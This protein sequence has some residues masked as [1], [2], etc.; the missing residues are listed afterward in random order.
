MSMS[1]W[2]ENEVKLACKRENPDREDDE[3]DYGCACYESALKAYKC[4]IED[5]HSG[6][7]FGFTKNI[8]IRLMNG[9]PLTPIEGSEEE[10]KYSFSM[11]DR[12]KVYQ[13]KRMDSL[14]RNIHPD[15]SITYDNLYDYFCI[16]ED[17]GLT[18]SAGGTKDVLKDYCEPITFPYWPTEKKWEV[19]T[20]EYLTDRKNGDFDTKEYLYIISPNGI[21][22]DVNRYFGETDNGWEEISEEEFRKRVMMDMQRKEAEEKRLSDQ[23]STKGG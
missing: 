21:R 3:W 1:E 17:S 11:E 14:F 8:L 2:A 12:T 6:M 4:L 5:G 13:N 16:D 7:S 18:Y 9:L 23:I 22:I 10:W 15:G 19:H 20:R